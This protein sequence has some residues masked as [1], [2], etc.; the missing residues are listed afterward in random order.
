MLNS[1]RLMCFAATTRA[2]EA[3]RFYRDVLGLRLVDDGPFALEFDANGTMLRIQKVDALVPATHTTLGWQVAD[4]RASI[5]DLA[6]HG[7]ELARYAGM[8]QDERGIWCSPS[9]AQVA[10]FR[11]PDGN[12]L[13]LTQFS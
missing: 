12:T 5:D 6:K 10:W 4:I 11:D 7:V 8:P 1:A 2:E 3:R 13:S 9:G